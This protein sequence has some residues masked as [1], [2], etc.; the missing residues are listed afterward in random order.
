MEAE[1]VD[2]IAMRDLARERLLPALPVGPVHT[3]MTF[4]G[5]REMSAD[6]DLIAGGVQLPAYWGQKSQLPS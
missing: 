3:G 5:S 2:L 6:A 1:V 4:D